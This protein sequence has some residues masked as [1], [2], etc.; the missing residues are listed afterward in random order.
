MIVGDIP[1]ASSLVSAWSTEGKR[2]RIATF[3]VMD[4]LIIPWLKKKQRR[5]K[6]SQS[7]NQKSYTNAPHA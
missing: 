1:E 3:Q 2:Y 7:Q 4:G 5:D 6:I